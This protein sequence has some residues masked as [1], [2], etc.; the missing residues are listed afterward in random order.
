[1]EIGAGLPTASG[2]APDALEA[3]IRPLRA[4]AAKPPPQL[5]CALARTPN[6]P[7][8]R[9]ATTPTRQSGCKTR[10][11]RGY[12][13]KTLRCQF[14]EECVRHPPTAASALSFTLRPV[15]S[16]L[17]VLQSLFSFQRFCFPLLVLWSMVAWSRCLIVPFQ[18]LGMALRALA[19]RVRP[20]AFAGKCQ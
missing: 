18:P 11:E 15:V 6:N 16:G 17:G 4:S 1:M 2:R 9:E 5:R 13:A 10:C 12:A 3:I 20:W 8:Y 19:F 7:G 14:K